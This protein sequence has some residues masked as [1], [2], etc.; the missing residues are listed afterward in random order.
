MI[1]GALAACS[2]AALVL[3]RRYCATV[4]RA[5]AGS[6]RR[7]G[8][9]RQ[10]ASCSASARLL[11]LRSYGALADPRA[12]LVAGQPVLRSVPTDAEQRAAAEDR[13]P[14]ARWW[15]SSATSSAGSKSACAA[16]KPA[17]CATATWCRS[18]RRRALMTRS[19]RPSRRG[20]PGARVPPTGRRCGGP[21]HSKKEGQ[22]GTFAP[23]IEAAAGAAAVSRVQRFA[24]RVP[25]PHDYHRVA[26][27]PAGVFRTQLWLNPLRSACSHPSFAGCS[28][29]P[30]RFSPWSS[31]RWSSPPR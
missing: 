8:R 21:N 17:G 3:R 11:G 29:Q 25:S 31:W 22:G 26:H 19:P 10:R 5:A 9:W 15:S 14:P 7:D 30:S 27:T 20:G 24:F 18:T 16:A 1:A 4:P 12:A 23:P 2:G 13:S 28:S 6:R